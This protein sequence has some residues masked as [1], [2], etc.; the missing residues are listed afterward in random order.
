MPKSHVSLNTK[1]LKVLKAFHSSQGHILEVVPTIRDSCPH[2]QCERL[3]N[4]GY[5]PPQ[6]LFYGT[7]N[8]EPVYIRIR[9]KKYQCLGCKRHFRQSL[10]HVERGARRYCHVFFETLCNIMLRADATKAGI[11]RSFG[12]P[13]STMYRKTKL[14]LKKEEKSRSNNPCPRVLGIDEKKFNKRLGYYTCLVDFDRGHRILDL[15]P[16]K[17][18]AAL[19]SHLDSLVDRH[20]VE[21][22]FCDLCPTIRAMVKMAFP[23]AQIVADRYHVISLVNRY[24]YQFWRALDPVAA[25]NRSVSSLMRYHEWNLKPESRSKLRAYLATNELVEELYDFKQQLNALLL[26]RVHNTLQAQRAISEFL[27]LLELMKTRG[28]EALKSLA[29][30]LESWQEEIVRMWRYSRTNS[31]TEGV[32]RVLQGINMKAYGYRNFE[33]F[34]LYALAK[35][36]L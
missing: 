31:I 35:T 3:R 8:L 29:K 33:M 20:R 7:L 32:N 4:K 24:F 25:K 6:T 13:I 22:V 2:C 26:T 17:S 28:G 18:T 15:I 23:K 11:A 9:K 10:P 19:A 1:Y 27:R 30:T 5:N 16:G 14:W 36:S 34:R 21:V 12:I